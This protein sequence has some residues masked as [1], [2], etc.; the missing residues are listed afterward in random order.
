M[1]SDI[2][3][4][5]SPDPNVPNGQ[6][7][8]QL[9]GPYSLTVSDQSRSVQNWSVPNSGRSQIYQLARALQNTH[10]MTPNSEFTALAT[11]NFKPQRPQADFLQVSGTR[12]LYTFSRNAAQINV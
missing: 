10:T 12:E 7:S 11:P 8:G 2:P 1:V 3:D 9:S 4:V 6:I 5:I